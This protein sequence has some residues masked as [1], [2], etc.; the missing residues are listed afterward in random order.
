MNKLGDA[1][2]N[3][4]FTPDDVTKLQQLKDLEKIK[5]LLHGKAE[6]VAVKHVIDCDSDP[7]VPDGWIV[8]KHIKGGQFEFNPFRIELYLDEGQENGG[9]VVGNELRKLLTGKPVLNVNVLDY[10]LAHTELIPEEWK[11]KYIFFWGTIYRDS[12]G[13]LFVRYLFWRGDRWHWNY[14]WLDNDFNGSYP[15]ALGK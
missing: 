8:E 14:Y 2:E 1:L 3:A 7:F 11:G 6:I 5:L 12:D 9:R 10:L 13:N 15:A 4:N